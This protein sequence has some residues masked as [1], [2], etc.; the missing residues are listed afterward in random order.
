MENIEKS[1]V[2]QG[3]HGRIGEI[4]HGGG[5]GGGLLRLDWGLSYKQ[6]SMTES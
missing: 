1:A 2:F 5:G 4:L 6:D 3:G